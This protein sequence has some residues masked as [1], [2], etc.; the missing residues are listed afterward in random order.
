MLCV[1]VYLCH[2]FIWKYFWI[3]P[4][5]AP[6]VFFHCLVEHGS[7]SR[8]QYILN[9]FYKFY[10]FF[11]FVRCYCCCWSVCMQT[12]ENMYGWKRSQWF[13]AG[14]NQPHIH[15]QRIHWPGEETCCLSS[16]STILYHPW[17]VK[18]MRS[19]NIHTSSLKRELSFR[20][21][22]VMYNSSPSS[23]S[24]LKSQSSFPRPSIRGANGHLK[25]LRRTYLKYTIWQ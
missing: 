1:L 11:G 18:Y 24:S 15:A 14:N 13:G 21:H 22:I 19:I 2:R 6:S 17:N 20:P 7:F 16:I 10:C 3:N 25:W 4:Y 23:A 9:F 8:M 5:N 12:Q